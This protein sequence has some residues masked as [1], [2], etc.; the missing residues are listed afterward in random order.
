ML[1]GHTDCQTDHVTARSMA[2]VLK[3]GVA[4]VWHD[5]NAC[6]LRYGTRSVQG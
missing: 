4:Y 5:A 6:F 2:L 3:Q 1:G